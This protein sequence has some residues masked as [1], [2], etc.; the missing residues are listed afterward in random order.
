MGLFQ[1]DNQ[2][3][4]AVVCTSSGYDPTCSEFCQPLEM[5]SSSANGSIISN[6][7]LLNIFL[8][9]SIGLIGNFFTIATIVNA[10]RNHKEEFRIFSHSSTP[11]LIHLAICDMLYCAVGLPSFG[12][13]FVQHYFPL[14]EIW[15]RLLA[16]F[17]NI[18]AY[19]DFLTLGLIS[20]DLAC[21]YTRGKCLI[22][23]CNPVLVCIYLWVASFF[24]NSINIFN[25]TGSFGYDGVN[26]RC[27]AIPL[28]P[29]CS[30]SRSGTPQYLTEC[31]KMENLVWYRRG[32]H[33][34][35]IIYLGML[36]I[37][38]VNIS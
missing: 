16:M 1:F 23:N 4:S 30:V 33:G 19:T 27:E 31:K 7:F 12:I 5:L 29:D 36:T 34:G 35:Q 21:F 18:T 6:M 22:A 10:K 26:G 15:R 9:G 17:R 28:W 37:L 11:L 38:G 25:I 24:L 32:V 2:S 13:I 3:C 20:V 8:I 14:P